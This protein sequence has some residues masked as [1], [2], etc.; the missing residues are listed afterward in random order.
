M[1]N[2]REVAVVAK[3]VLRDNVIS[4]MEDRWGR[5]NKLRLAEEAGIGVSSA[6]RLL[7]AET[8]IGVDIIAKVAR[9][10]DLEA[11]QLMHPGLDPLNPPQTSADA[12]PRGM[13]LAKAL[14]AALEN[15][16]R[17]AQLHALLMAQLALYRGLF[18]DNAR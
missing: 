18:N 14:D 7:E 5:L 6:Q 1:P 2:K 3:Q 16:T 12:S 17:H 9:V 4:L 15:P 11:W 8:K 10:F 13:E